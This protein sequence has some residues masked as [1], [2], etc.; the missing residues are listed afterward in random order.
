MGISRKANKCLPVVVPQ[1]HPVASFYIVLMLIKLCFMFEA[2]VLM[3]IK[4]IYYEVELH[5]GT[6]AA[7]I[8]AGSSCKCKK[9]YVE[10]GKSAQNFKLTGLRIV[11]AK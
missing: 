1:S 2:I 3:L 4:F 8:S 6:P 9:T 11:A 7:A 5:S 10:I